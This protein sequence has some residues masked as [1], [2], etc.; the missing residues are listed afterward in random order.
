MDEGFSDSFFYRERAFFGKTVFSDDFC[1]GQRL[2]RKGIGLLG[3]SFTVFAVDTSTL[4]STFFIVLQAYAIIVS[5]TKSKKYLE[6]M[7]RHLNNFVWFFWI[8][9]LGIKFST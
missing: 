4:I 9:M 2:L 3:V 7:Q 8:W 1:L 5:A 6:W